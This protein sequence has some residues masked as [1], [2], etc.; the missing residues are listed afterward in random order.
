[1]LLL[2]HPI[3]GDSKYNLKGQSNLNKNKN[4]MLHSSQI[5]FMINNKKYTFNAPIPTYFEKYLKIK[6]LRFKTL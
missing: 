2:G 6:R 4:L 1:M 5:K 3:I